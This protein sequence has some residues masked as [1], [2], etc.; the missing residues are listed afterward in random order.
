MRELARKGF[1]PKYLV[2][3]KAVKCVAYQVGKSHVKSSDKSG[4]ILKV[5][6]VN[7]GDLV[8]M[9]QA[10]SS[11]PGRPLSYS[12]KN[13]NMKIVFVTLFID[14]I[15]KKVFYEFQ[16]S[17]GAEEIIKVKEA[18]EREATDSGV[19]IKSFRC[20]NDIFKLAEF[21]L[22]LKDSDK[23]ISYCGVGSRHQNGITERLIL[24]MVKKPELF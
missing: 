5:H 8:R 4:K 7:S 6:I 13:N 3:A 12:G 2:R 22:E 20:N 1:L 9:G 17:V 11:A 14:S 10:Q 24:T 18:M 23:T 21:R 15:S 19:A 16:H